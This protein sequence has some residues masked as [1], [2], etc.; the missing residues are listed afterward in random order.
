MKPED[1]F[2][3]TPHAEDGT[4]LPHEA[5]SISEQDAIKM[6]A[7]QKYK[8]D[9]DL[10]THHLNP[11][12]PHI[13]LIDRKDAEEAYILG[14]TVESFCGAPWQPTKIIPESLTTDWGD[15]N[16]CVVC[17]SE[18]FGRPQHYFKTKYFP[19]PWTEPIRYE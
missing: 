2:V 5:F 6:R 13:P 14:Q 15:H 1:Y 7:I 11:P 3:Q 19:K 16:C 4:V 18:R 8:R 10:R 12:V 17:L 9:R